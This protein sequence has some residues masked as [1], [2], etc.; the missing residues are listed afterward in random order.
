M[1]QINRTT[2]QEQS[3]DRPEN[4]PKS[5]GWKHVPRT[6]SDR[7]KIMGESADL[8]FTPEGRALVENILP[9]V[10]GVVVEITIEPL[11]D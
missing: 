3:I 6:D 1:E 5:V 10:E 8:F 4:A 7:G 9:D 11:Q 2:N